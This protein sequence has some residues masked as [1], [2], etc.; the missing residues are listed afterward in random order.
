MIKVKLLRENKEEVIGYE[1]DLTIE[2]VLRKFGY[3]SETAVV[4]RNGKINTEEEIVK[5][6]DEVFI[7]PVISGG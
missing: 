7:I 2:D 4:E 6:N 5:D 3:N 1:E